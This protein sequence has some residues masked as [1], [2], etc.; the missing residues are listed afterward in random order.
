MFKSTAF[1]SSLRDSFLSVAVFALDS[2]SALV[3]DKRWTI[4]PLAYRDIRKPL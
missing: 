4:E 2:A 1:D 3:P